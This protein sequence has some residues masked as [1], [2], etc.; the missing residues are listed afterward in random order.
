MVQDVIDSPSQAQE[1]ALLP[2]RLRKLEAAVA[3]LS[4]RIGRRYFTLLPERHAVGV[5][6]PAELLGAA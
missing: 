2:P 3:G 6:G 5:G 4:E 1:A